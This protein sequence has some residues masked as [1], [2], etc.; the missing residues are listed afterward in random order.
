MK[1]LVTGA[2]GF[3]GSALA[4]RLS[5]YGHDVCGIDNINGYYDPRLKIGRL[6]AAGITP[7]DEWGKV[8][9]TPA[10]GT[11]RDP[12][13]IPDF[14][15]HTP[16]RSATLP[17]LSFLRLDITDFDSLARL[18]DT[19]KF[20]VVI[21]LAAQAGVRYSIENPLSYGKNNLLGFL[22]VLEC[23]RRSAVPHFIYASSSS[24]YGAD[25]KIPFSEDDRV[26]TPASLYAATK[27]SNELMAAAYT[28][29]YGI[30]TVGLRFFTV[31]G[32]WGRPDMAPMLF[33]DAILSGKPIKVFNHG[34]L[35]RDFTFIDDIVEG[36]S[37]V[38]ESAPAA[39][40]RIYNIGRGEG[41]R[42]MDFIK[43][44][45]DNLGK[46][47]LLD[48]QP[49]QPGDVKDTWADTTNL[50]RDFGYTPSVSLAEGIE[51]FAKWRLSY[52][53]DSFI[54]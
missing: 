44:L 5:K 18:F 34:N 36:I 33:S 38:A 40:A 8:R 20:D 28:N 53:P 45:E 32:P 17:S 11:Y 19:E 30:P 29:L 52:L 21:N 12:V 6:K 47:A 49:M 24:V 46:K 23:S 42:L 51:S 41:V 15:W 25:H 43:L 9:V 26:D 13:E 2:A 31:Y 54:Q 22:N 27:K 16:L 10:T 37:R 50:K 4:L 7:S 48:M 39:G 1:I 3:I 35:S 14:P